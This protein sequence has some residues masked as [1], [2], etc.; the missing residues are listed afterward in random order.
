MSGI[1]SSFLS[2]LIPFRIHELDA[3]FADLQFHEQQFPQSPRDPKRL[4]KNYVKRTYESA[5][6]IICASCGCCY[7]DITEFDN[8]PP[9]Y[10]PLRHLSIPENISIPWNFSC[11]IDILDQN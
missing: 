5:V 8:V 9:S 6:N 7:H 11:G 1:K 4:Y 10:E 2:M 3:Q